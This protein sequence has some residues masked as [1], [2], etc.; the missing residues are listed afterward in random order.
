M[1]FP[2]LRTLKRF[3]PFMAW[4]PYV[5]RRTLRADALAGITVALVVIPQSLAY[6]QLAGLPPYYGLYAALIPTVVGALFGSSAQ[7]STGPVAL[8]SLLTAASI[9]PLAPPGGEQYIALA[10]AVALLSGI[11]QVGFGALR[12]GV[13]MNLL[14]HPVLMGFVN[15]AAILIGLS[16][17]PSLLGLPPPASG[18][19]L[20]DTWRTISSVDRAHL[21]S[22][23]F[24]GTAIALLVAFRRFAPR[25]PGVLV[26][27][28]VLT[29]AS[30]LLGFGAGGG[31][32]V[33][34]IPHGL[35]GFG[36]P[37]VQW[38]TW[39][40]LLPASFAIA[41]ISFME[42]M[43]SAKIAA[44]KTASRWNENQELIGQ[45]LAKIA[46]A[47]SQTMPVSGSFSRSALNL[48]ANALTGMSSLICAACVLVALL[49]FTPLLRHLPLPVLAAIIVMALWNLVNVRALR[50][51]WQ[52]SADDAL[53]ALLTFAATI[54]FAPQIQNGIFTGILASLA[55]FVYRR[56]WPRVTV[57][58]PA[59]EALARELP[60]EHAQALRVVLGLVRFD[61]SLVFVNVS[62]FE[63]AVLRLE[64]RYPNVRYIVISAYA[65]NSIDAS[66]AETLS[67]LVEGLNKRGITLVFT[68]VKPQVQD[69]LQR[70]GLAQRIGAGNFYETDY[71]AM[72]ALAGREAARVA[73]APADGARLPA[74]PAE[75]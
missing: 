59:S 15:A 8:T 47:F 24:G 9:A 6:A 45:G 41:V 11:F 7:L 17:L 62:Y 72:V 18:H 32:I 68:G 38:D 23:A 53:A 29:A 70:T 5:N 54:A 65:I 33:G 35:P 13:L 22:L 26:T 34:D 21:L 30:H 66:G 28:A 19:A 52:A 1:S 50:H 55:L 36:L 20:S 74:A 48:A 61:A 58:E 67:S 57:A 4:L 12:L 25:W 37:A 75:G 64:S 31:R 49:F 42:A 43:S 63:Q 3:L 2:A 44:V 56:M 39:I 16:Q 46:A 69:V 60:K 27:V 73:S 71:A 10:V 40:A 14:S 51:A